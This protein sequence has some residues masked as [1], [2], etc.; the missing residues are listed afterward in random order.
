MCLPVCPDR[1]LTESIGVHIVFLV[2]RR[3]VDI[4]SVVKRAA[5][6]ESQL[7]PLAIRL[8]RR[9]DSVLEYDLG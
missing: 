8:F 4:V 3:R 2:D 7:V 1:T 6:V 9:L 5:A